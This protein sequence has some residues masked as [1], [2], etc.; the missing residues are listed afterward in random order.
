MHQVLN[1][2][3]SIE[4]CTGG[5]EFLRKLVEELVGKVV[6]LEVPALGNVGSAG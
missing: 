5:L 1:E 3:L 4:F 6:G 2:F